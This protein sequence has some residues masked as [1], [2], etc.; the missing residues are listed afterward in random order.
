[1]A[2]VAFVASFN[3][4]TTLFV[5]VS[6]K[7]RDI[8]ILKALGA[9]RFKI[10]SIFLKQSIF[11]GVIGGVAGVFLAL[12][13]SYILTHYPFITLP[14]IYLLTTLPIQMDWQVYAAVAGAG[15]LISALAGIYPALL[16]SRVQA[17]KGIAGSREP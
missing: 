2:L 8:S 10:I 11:M 16:A 6:Q 12:F 7:Q 4:L 15:I 13:L 1:M 5:S 3:I 9:S 14:D 17:A